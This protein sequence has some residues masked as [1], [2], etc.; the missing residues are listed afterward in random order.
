MCPFLVARAKQSF[1]SK[2]LVLQCLVGSEER[3]SFV[4]Q[5]GT[6]SNYHIILGSRL[7]KFLRKWQNRA[8]M[9]AK[10]KD[11]ADWILLARAD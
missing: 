11:R 4:V 1:V 2:S 8:L 5:N 9:F 10:Y 3:V 7:I 6:A